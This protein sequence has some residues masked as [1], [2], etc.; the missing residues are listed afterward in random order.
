MVHL[1][2]KLISLSPWGRVG[3]NPENEVALSCR[4]LDPRD[5]DS[6]DFKQIATATFYYGGEVK[7]PKND[8]VYM[9][10]NKI[11][12]QNPTT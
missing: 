2:G 11:V 1:V 9:L 8:A 5:K 10:G 4:D 12:V 3:E 6:R 7:K